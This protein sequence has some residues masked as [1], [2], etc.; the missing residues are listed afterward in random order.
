M[1]IYIYIHIHLSLSL[2][3]YIY[4]FHRLFILTL[5]S[6]IRT[7]HAESERG[8]LP[9]KSEPPTLTRAPDNQFRRL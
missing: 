2:Y 8:S 6:N 9:M 3:I 4:V 1:Y 7:D 5:K